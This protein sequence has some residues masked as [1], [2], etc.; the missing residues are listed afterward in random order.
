MA[1]GVLVV[2]ARLTSFP[3]PSRSDLSVLSL[4][5]EGHTDQSPY[6]CVYRGRRG[7]W[8]ARVRKRLELGSSYHSPEEAASAVI[9]WY[10]ARYGAAWEAAFRSRKVNPFRLRPV[11]KGEGTYWVAE[12]WVE[13][14]ITTVTGRRDAYLWQSRDAARLAL[15]AW[16]YHQVGLFAPLLLWRPVAGAVAPAPG[17]PP[18]VR[19]RPVRRPHRPRPPR[20]DQPVLFGDGD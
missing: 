10:K 14:R 2:V 12:V 19:P 8:R 18:P 20:G 5:R 11:R 13:G 17:P 6:A 7:L 4:D 1:P 15:R 3:K 9:G 16:L